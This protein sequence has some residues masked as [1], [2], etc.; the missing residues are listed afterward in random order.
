MSVV[1]DQLKDF[2]LAELHALGVERVSLMDRTAMSDEV[3]AETLATRL[4][5]SAEEA[6]P[7]DERI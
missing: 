3:L 4:L 1:H 2:I 5:A 7:L 6:V